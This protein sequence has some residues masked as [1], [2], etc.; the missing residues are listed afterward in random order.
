MELQLDRVTKQYQNKIAVDRLSLNMQPG[1]I[2]LLGANGAGKTTLMR[3][4]CGILRRGGSKEDA[5]DAFKALFYGEDVRAFYPEEAMRL[6]TG[7]MVD[8]F[9]RELLEKPVL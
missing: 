8:L 9:A 4:I 3:M 2:G 6:N 5:I 1:V 7:L